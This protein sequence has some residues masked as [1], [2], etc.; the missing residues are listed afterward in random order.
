MKIILTIFVFVV[1]FGGYWIYQKPTDKNSIYVNRL[2]YLKRDSSLFSGTLEINETPHKVIYRFYKGLP[3]DKWE[4]RF[5]GDLV[6]KG[7]YLNTGI[8]CKG[9]RNLILTDTFF[10]DHWQEG[11]LPTVKYPPNLSLIIL[12]GNKFFELDKK[13]YEMY[14]RQ[15]AYAVKKDVHTLKFD[16][17]KISFVNAVYDWS[18]DY[19]KE[20]YVKDDKLIEI[21]CQE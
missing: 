5:K 17:L 14:F 15:L 6:Q 12:K 3:C 2:V 21:S 13:Q 1:L 20:Y 11:E 9:T 7:E 4:Y 18:N 8:L 16:Y 19:S 10:I